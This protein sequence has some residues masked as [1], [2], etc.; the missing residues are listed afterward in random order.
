MVPVFIFE[1]KSGVIACP[2][3]GRWPDSKRRVVVPET[4]FSMLTKEQR[5][6]LGRLAYRCREQGP[7]VFLDG[8]VWAESD[9]EEPLLT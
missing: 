3:D 2:K 5:D 6:S 4:T 1:D 8:N 7:F 9:R